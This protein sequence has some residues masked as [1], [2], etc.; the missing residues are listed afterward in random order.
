MSD[1]TDIIK[2]FVIFVSDKLLRNVVAICRQADYKAFCR[3]FTVII[4]RRT[5]YHENSVF[6]CRI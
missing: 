6:P 1:R 5:T 3:A 2:L 4:G